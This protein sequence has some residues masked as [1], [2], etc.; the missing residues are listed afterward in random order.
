MSNNGSKTPQTSVD[1]MLGLGYAN[2]KVDQV[3][4]SSLISAKWV[5]KNLPNVTKV[6]VIGT[7][8]VRD[9][10][11]AEGIAVI[12]AEQDIIPYNESMGP[13]EFEKIELDPEVGAVV[14]SIDFSFN[15]QKMCLASV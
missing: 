13:E 14:V 15:L 12:G 5:K 3:V 7:K 11:E 1:K 8:A 2:P 10:F 6:F 4:M 9:T